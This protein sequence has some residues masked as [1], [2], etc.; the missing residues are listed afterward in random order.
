M[1]WISPLTCVWVI[2]WPKVWHGE[3]R[4]HGLPSSPVPE[5][6]VISDWDWAGPAAQSINATTEVKPVINF[7][8]ASFGRRDFTFSRRNFLM[9]FE[10]AILPFLSD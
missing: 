9:M 8:V 5:T 6:K 2:A 7:M 1:Q 10:R 3:A 4:L